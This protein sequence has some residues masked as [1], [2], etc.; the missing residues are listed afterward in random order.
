[1]VLHVFLA[2]ML[3]LT[4]TVYRSTALDIGGC[5]IRIPFQPRLHC[6][7]SNAWEL[8]LRCNVVL[9]PLRRRRRPGPL[10]PSCC[11]CHEG[12]RTGAC[13]SIT[14]SW[15][16][17]YGEMLIAAYARST[18]RCLQTSAPNFLLWLICPPVRLYMYVNVMHAGACWLP[19]CA[20]SS[21]L[22]PAQCGPW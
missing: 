5:G 13:V 8:E 7:Q 19:L 21:L 20:L 2:P 16:N 14:V 6:R 3:A 11:H 9:G 15:S 22:L 17:M 4:R 1:M 12:H 18:G 10:G